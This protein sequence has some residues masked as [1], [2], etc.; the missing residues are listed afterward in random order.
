MSRKDYEKF[1]RKIRAEMNAARTIKDAMFRT[2]EVQGLYNTAQLCADVFAEDNPSF[3]KLRFLTA[4]GV[5]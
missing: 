1:A 5:E 3:D 4:C 2:Q